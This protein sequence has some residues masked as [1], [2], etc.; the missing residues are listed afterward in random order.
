[1]PVQAATTP[2]AT[3]TTVSASRRMGCSRSLGLNTGHDFSF[4]AL[5]LVPGLVSPRHM[6]A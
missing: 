1:M 3:P 2:T 6:F 5:S 4:P